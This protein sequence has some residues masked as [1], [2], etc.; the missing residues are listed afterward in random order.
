MAK[1][2]R[3]VLKPVKPAIANVPEEQELP[4]SE[5]G[6]EDQNQAE[7][8][9][10]PYEELE[11]EIPVMEKPVIN[12][13]SQNWADEMEQVD[14]QLS[15]EDIVFEGFVKRVWGNLGVEKIVR[16]HPGFTL[17][18]FKDEATRDLVLETGVIHYDK[19]QVVLRP[20]SIDMDTA[21]MVKSVP[22]WIRLNGLGLQYWGRNSLSALVSTIGKLI[23]MDKVTQEKS[24]IK[25]AR[26]LVDIDIS[27]NP[28]KAISF[29]NEKKQMVEQSIEYE[30]LPSKYSRGSE[31]WI[32]PR[33][34]R[35]KLVEI[36]CLK[37]TT[38]N[39]YDVLQ[40]NRDGF[41]ETTK[42]QPVNGQYVM[43]NNFRSW[44]FY[45]CPI[46]SYRIMLL[47]QASYVNVEI[48]V[49]DDQFVHCKIRKIGDKDSC[50][51]TAVYGSNSMTER[52]SLWDKFS[53]LGHLKDH[54]IIFGD[55][56]AMFSYGDRSGGRQ[57]TPRDIQDA[58]DLLAKG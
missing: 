36:A 28:P 53:T 35:H 54:W 2:K 1:K 26:I 50:Y 18:R 41:G 12:P 4:L 58:Q 24:M 31:N 9:L 57:M 3:N 13:L 40:N 15:A 19:K 42:T 49:E 51:V 47:W 33:K 29:I 14:Y 16:M 10:D 21:Q 38:S 25:F 48:L 44:N 46:I 43:E 17:V 8:I 55:F 39:G 22:V 11:P 6:V 37:A 7:V 52:I 27:D 34:K 23:M 56:N 32:T 20:W 45:S 30:W 5:D